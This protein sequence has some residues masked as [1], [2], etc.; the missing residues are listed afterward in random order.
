MPWCVIDVEAGID[1][2]AAVAVIDHGPHH[3]CQPHPPAVQPGR[4]EGDD[5]R[6][7]VPRPGKCRRGARL[8][9]IFEKPGELVL[10]V[11]AGQQMVAD[12]PGPTVSQAVVEALVVAIVE[13]WLL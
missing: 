4:Q 12:R 6:S 8:V 5:R 9:M 7:L 3:A 13:A 10:V 1:E 2:F 11:E